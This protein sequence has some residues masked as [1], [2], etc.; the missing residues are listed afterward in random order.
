M[1]AVYREEAVLVV[2]THHLVVAAKSK[3]T[4]VRI[5]TVPLII[6]VRINLMIVSLAE[7]NLVPVKL[8]VAPMKSGLEAAKHVLVLHCTHVKL[9]LAQ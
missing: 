9:N 2:D 6:L 3:Q 1:V 4:A 7:V 5:V 8:L